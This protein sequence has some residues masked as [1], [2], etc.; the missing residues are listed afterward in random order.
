MAPLSLGVVHERL[1]RTIM[2]LGVS[3]IAVNYLFF[4]ATSDHVTLLLV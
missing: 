4:G 3:T 2:L 1:I